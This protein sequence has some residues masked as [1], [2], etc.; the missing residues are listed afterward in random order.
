MK[1][2]LA[3]V[4]AVFFGALLPTLTRLLKDEGWESKPA[5]AIRML[6]GALVLGPLLGKQVLGVTKAWIPSLVSTLAFAFG[7]ALYVFATQHAPPGLVISLVY[8]CPVWSVLYERWVVKEHTPYGLLAVGCGL[9]GTVLLSQG[10]AWDKPTEVAGVA[11]A[12]V[13]SVIFAAYLVAGRKMSEA[14]INPAV[15][16]F[17]GAVISGVLFAPDLV[18]TPWSWTSAGLGLALGVTTCV[19]YPLLMGYG[20]QRVKSTVE[21]SVLQYA[22]IVFVWAFA[23]AAGSSWTGLDLAG[24]GCIVLAGCVI[25]VGRRS[26]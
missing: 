11:A 2:R 25:A 13:D 18:S 19:F 24:S 3:L 23:L 20:L 17:W 7:G 12:L 15:S 1:G 21:A 14:A 5:S 8:L 10:L 6:V 26:A 22:E 16:L 4:G 9:L